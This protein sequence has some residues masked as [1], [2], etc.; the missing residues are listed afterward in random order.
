MTD[1]PNL[2]PQE[3]QYTEVILHTVQLPD[4]EHTIEPLDDSAL[5]TAKIT[6][7]GPEDPRGKIHRAGSVVIEPKERGVL[8][9]TATRRRDANLKD[10]TEAEV[11]GPAGPAGSGR[12]RNVQVKDT[13][14]TAKSA[15]K[16]RYRPGQGLVNQPAA[17]GGVLTGGGN[18]RRRGGSGRRKPE[19]E[20]ETGGPPQI[21][22]IFNPRG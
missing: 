18:K 7:V 5:R 10:P 16:M 13:S 14:K 9:Q 17:N 11:A 22:L 4:G 20:E 21:N 1:D 15:G 19:D 3:I 2:H 8:L 6:A 12:E